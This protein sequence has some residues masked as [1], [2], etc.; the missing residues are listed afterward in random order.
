MQSDLAGFI[1][2]TMQHVHGCFAVECVP[3]LLGHVLQRLQMGVDAVG[4]I[5][6][7][8]GCFELLEDVVKVY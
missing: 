5:I 4:N 7:S 8:K 1:K 3:M 2:Y 6:V